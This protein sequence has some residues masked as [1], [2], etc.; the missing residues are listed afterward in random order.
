VEINRRAG[1]AAR[2]TARAALEV[3]NR[4]AGRNIVLNRK[5]RR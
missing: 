1:A 5:E 3:I 2:G 4:V